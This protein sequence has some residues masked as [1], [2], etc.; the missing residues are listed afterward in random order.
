[1][2]HPEFQDRLRSRWYQESY[3]S[4]IIS[5][6]SVG[7]YLTKNFENLIFHNEGERNRKIGRRVRSQHQKAMRI[8]TAA[9]PRFNHPIPK[10]WYHGSRT[11][12]S[13]INEN[14]LK[15]N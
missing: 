4:P 2:G 15:S 9:I 10:P 6:D 1:M 8:V 12:N 11:P 14:E 5:P 3:I 7:A 13:K